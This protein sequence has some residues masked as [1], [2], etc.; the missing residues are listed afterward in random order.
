[1]RARFDRTAVGALAM[2]KRLKLDIRTLVVRLRRPWQFA[3]G[4]VQERELVLV[5][6]RDRE[7]V[8][9]F[10]EAA[11]LPEYDHTGSKQVR[12]ALAR[13]RPRVQSDR[14]LADPDADGA[15]ALA[16]L[17]EEVRAEC[18]QPHALAALEIALLDLL[19]K[20]AGLPLWR[21]LAGASAPPDP[22][23]ITLNGA[24]GAIAP[25]LAGQLAQELAEEGF[26]TIKVKVGTGEEDVR[27]VARV[28]SAAG[29][30]VALR[31][32]ANGAWSRQQASEQLAPLERFALEL[33]EEPVHGAQ[34]L[35]ALKGEVG[36][37][38][39]A[40]ESALE[41]ELIEARAVDA[42]C[43]KVGRAGGIGALIA[44]ARSARKAGLGV[45]LASNLD[46]PLGIAAAL[47]AAAALALEG[48]LAPCGLA[49]LRQLDCETGPLRIDRG[50]MR[51]PQ[52]P[53]LGL[54]PPRA[55]LARKYARDLSW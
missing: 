20:R 50:R 55:A 27:R 40:D 43:L 19:A 18:A 37:R 4:I 52:S 31:L 35:A 51:P 30:Q 45:Y 38:I 23:T 14:E 44:R 6:V 16:C 1:L 8:R 26:A 24:V 42:L 10:G 41:P 32:D 21:L 54:E 2:R 11:P 39:A 28:R 9:G 47:H 3:G 48:P 17:L 12:A 15:R 25:I 49:T 53:G 34:E 13:L 29:A 36:V 5:S 7:G 22:P 33:V 46:G